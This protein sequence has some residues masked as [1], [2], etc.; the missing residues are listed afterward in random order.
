MQPSNFTVPASDGIELFVHHWLPDGETRAV[1]QVVHGLAEH[2]ARYGRLAESLARA[3]IA[4]Y[5]HDQR[6]HGRTAKKP[7]EL[8]F[9]GEKDG[10]TQAANDLWLVN[11][12]IAKEHAGVP[13]VML[14]HSMGSTLAL[15][16]IESHGDAL[17]GVVLSAPSGMPTRMA[18]VGKLMAR[19]E[20][21][22]LGP[23]GHS[24]I[25]QALTFGAFNRSFSPARTPFDWLSRD[26][27]EVDKYIADPHCG[28]PASVQLWLEMLDVF[29]KI[30]KPQ[31]LAKIPRDLP[32]YI[33]AGERDPVSAECR[34]I[35]P[36]L[37]ALR[38]AGVTNI[39]HRFYPD[40]R[41]EL[42]NETNRDEV[43]RD[44]K[45]W[46]EAVLAG[47]APTAASGHPG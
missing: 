13:I 28:F 47:Y 6:G 29:V 25:I 23:R 45:S 9:F 46:L 43:I 31:R 35:R 39:K 15:E 3:G 33:M 37:E 21:M 22:R 5:A 16:F 2:A 41:H 32:I 27:E 24:G 8:G 10:W 44:L 11:R 7:E 34:Q 4:L 1:V 30:S 40:A 12:A 17:A 19:L 36:I 14:G 38:A 42:L 20:R 26:R 18:A